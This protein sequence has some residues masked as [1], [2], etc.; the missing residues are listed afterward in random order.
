MNG[1]N[2]GAE[3]LVPMVVERSSRGER[4][5]DIFSRLLKERII[6]LGG[7]I[8]DQIANLVVAQLLYLDSEAPDQEIRLYINSPGGS[9]TAGLAIYDTMHAVNADVSTVCMGFCGSMA[10]IVLAGGEAGKRY[11]LPNSTVHMHPAASGMQGY[12]PD[13]EIMARELLRKQQLGRELLARDSGQSIDRIAQDF[14]RD[15][16]MNA[17]QAKE[18]GIIDQILIRE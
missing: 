16:F 1:Q 12:A 5:F 2:L 13:V 18:Y 11:A 10:T 8:D 17:Q 6:M 3:L 7:P 9:V 14:D 4:A 15:L